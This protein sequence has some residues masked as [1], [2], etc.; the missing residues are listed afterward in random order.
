MKVTTINMGTLKD[1]S[2]PFSSATW[3]KATKAQEEKF[4]AVIA[5]INNKRA[6]LS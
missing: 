2:K 5:D 1:K 4:Y 3:S 6:E